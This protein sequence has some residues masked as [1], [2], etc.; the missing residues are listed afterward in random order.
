M[1]DRGSAFGE[2]AVTLAPSCGNV[3]FGT[4][5]ARMM[6]PAGAM[7]RV[8]TEAADEIAH[9]PMTAAWERCGEGILH[10]D[11]RLPWFPVASAASGT[12]TRA[13]GSIRRIGE[14]HVATGGRLPVTA[15]AMPRNH[16]PIQ[17]AG[18]SGVSRVSKTFVPKA[19][20]SRAKI[21]FYPT[22]L[23]CQNSDSIESSGVTLTITVTAS[24]TNIAMS[25]GAR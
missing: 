5:T 15:F 21:V 2:V 19:N 13:V 14:R 22:L 6:A 24:E 8:P 25:N 10:D 17:A 12:P 3:R 9:W 1:D 23:D 11:R 7:R 4:S 16:P 20:P 18:A